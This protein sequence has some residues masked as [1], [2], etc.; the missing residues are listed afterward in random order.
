MVV[1]AAENSDTIN[2]GKIA[3]RLMCKFLEDDAKKRMG[4]DADSVDAL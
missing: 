4:K 2:S 3:S 1:C